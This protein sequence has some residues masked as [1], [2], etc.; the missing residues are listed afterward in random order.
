MDELK[1]IEAV[2]VSEAAW[3]LDVSAAAVYQW[4]K[5]GKIGHIRLV[6]IIKIP[7][8]EIERI[9][10]VIEARYYFE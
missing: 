2:S 6:G 10:E 9:G 5:S 3:A 7:L 8:S 4:V 1:P